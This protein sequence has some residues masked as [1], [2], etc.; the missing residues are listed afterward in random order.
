[1]DLK[2]LAGIA[3]MVLVAIL[4]V[5]LEKRGYLKSKRE[6][7]LERAGSAGHIIPATLK[8]CSSSTHELD[9]N[10]TERR[11]T[12]LYEYEVNGLPPKVPPEPYGDKAA[13][14]SVPILCFKP[15]PG[16]F[17]LSEWKRNLRHSDADH[18]F[19]GRHAD[20][21]FAGRQGYIKVNCPSLSG[22]RKHAP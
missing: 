14:H 21:F 5:S 19:D 15:E 16:L 2:V 13:P 9:R 22:Y 18:P 10:A 17:R 8:K 11:F 1:M 3:V 12:G 20:I 4:E 6:R 7:D